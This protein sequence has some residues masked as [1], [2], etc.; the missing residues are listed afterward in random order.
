MCSSDLTATTEIYTLS[1]HDAFRSP[2]E[3]GLA[4]LVLA[5]DEIDRGGGEFLIHRLHPLLHEGSGVLDLAVGERVDDAA[6]AE[7]LLELGALRIV[8][9]LRLFLGIQVIEVAEELVEAVVRGE[10]SSLSPR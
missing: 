1:L 7:S 10:D 3:E 6:R 9:I 5:I 2:T 8:G 4:R